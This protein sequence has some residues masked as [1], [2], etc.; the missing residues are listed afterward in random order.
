MP[1]QVFI[2]G[3]RMNITESEQPVKDHCKNMWW[4]DKGTKKITYSFIDAYHSLCID[5]KDIISSELEA[6]DSL[7]MTL[8]NGS[9]STGYRIRN[10]RIKNGN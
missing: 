6:C 2:E 8:M 9:R 5:K 1:D 4:K 7:L 10:G 3:D